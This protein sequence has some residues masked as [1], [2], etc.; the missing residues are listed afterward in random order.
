MHFTY[1]RRFSGFLQDLV[2]THHVKG[3]AEEES[4][5]TTFV[6]VDPSRKCRSF[7]SLS[8]L[9]RTQVAQD[10]NSNMGITRLLVTQLV[11]LWWMEWVWMRV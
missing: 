10:D 2:Y 5:A 1:A 8:P 11:L 4:E 7:D 3:I 9:W 6:L